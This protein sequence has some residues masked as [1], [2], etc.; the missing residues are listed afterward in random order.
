MATPSGVFCAG[1]R[2]FVADLINHRIQIF[3]PNGDYKYQFGRH[4]VIGHE[5]NGRVHY[6]SRVAVAGASSSLAVALVRP[7][8][9]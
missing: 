6:P 8:R 1:D 3:D 5:G 4:P 7:S 2:V 9:P